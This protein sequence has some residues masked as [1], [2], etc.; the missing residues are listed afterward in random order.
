MLLSLDRGETGV[1]GSGS[2]RGASGVAK[3]GGARNSAA[4]ANVGG[5]DADRLLPRS[6]QRPPLSC[7]ASIGSSSSPPSAPLPGALERAN[8]EGFQTVIG[9]PVAAAAAAAA[10]AAAGGGAG[11]RRES[12]GEERGLFDDGAASANSSAA[13][14][15]T[16]PPSWWRFMIRRDKLQPLSTSSRPFAGR[17]RLNVGKALY[18]PLPCRLRNRSERKAKE[19]SF[20]SSFFGGGR[21]ASGPLALGRLSSFHTQQPRRKNALARSRWI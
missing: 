6:G 3:K 13:S 20:V 16:P 15:A 21:R 9:P 4:V 5:S 18:S 1:G 2:G 10:P 7:S 11:G 14:C 12:C 8:G 17:S 19:L